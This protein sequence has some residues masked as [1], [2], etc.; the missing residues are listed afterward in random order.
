[1]LYLV[2]YEVPHV[3][4]DSA[5]LGRVA[6]AS[7]VEQALRGVAVRHAGGRYGQ[8]RHL[9]NAPLLVGAALLQDGAREPRPRVAIVVLVVA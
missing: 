4:V 1:M 7:R 2:P 6:Q 9:D 5:N 3:Y 8:C